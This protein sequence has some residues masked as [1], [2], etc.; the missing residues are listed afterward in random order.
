MTCAEA[1]ALEASILE[2][3]N[4][5]EQELDDAGAELIDDPAHKQL[6]Q[7]RINALQ[8]ELAALGVR[9]QGARDQIAAQCPDDL[10]SIS[11]TFD[12]HSEN[13]NADT[14]LHVFVKNRSNTSSTPERQRDFFSNLAA[15]QRHAELGT[16]DKNPYLGFGESLGQGMSFDAGS[17]HTFDIPLRA[18]PIPMQEIVLPVVNVHILPNGND[19]WMFSYTVTFVFNDGRSF[20]ATS[21]TDGVTGII[22]DQ[23]QNNRNHSG[24]CI[25]NPFVPPPVPWK[26]QTDAV[27]TR[28]TLAFATHKGDG[29]NKNADTRLNIHIANRLG[30]TSAQDIAVSL[31]VLQGTEFEEDSLHT[32]DFSV[33]DLPL[34]GPPVPLRDIVLPVVYLDIAPTGNDR[35]AF[36]YQVTYFFSNGQRFSSRTN[37][38]VLDQHHH[39]HAGV[40]QGDPFPTVTP[41]PSARNDLTG[42]AIDHLDPPKRISLSYLQRRLDE[43]VNHRQGVGSQD[44]PI[45]RIRLHHSGVYGSTLPESSYDLQSITAD[46]PPPGTVTAPSFKERVTW[47]S[48]P[49]SIG[50]LDD[51]YFINLNTKAIA[52]TIDLLHLGDPAPLTVFIDFDV[53]SG[54]DTGGGNAMNFHEFNIRFQF[55][56]AFNGAHQRVDVL[57]WMDQV[58]DLDQLDKFVNVKVVTPHTTDPGGI[59]QRK[60]RAQIFETLRKP[61]PFDGT[62]M[63]DRINAVVNSWLLGETLDGPNGCTVQDVG[64]DGDE[65]VISYTGPRQ[66]FAPAQPAD[67]PPAGFSPGRLANIDHIVVLTMENRSFDHLLGYLSLPPAKGGMGRTDVDGLQGDEANVAN[68]VVCPS[69]PLPPGD[70]IFPPDPPHGYEPVAKAINGG[71]MDGFAQSYADAHGQAVAPRIMGYHTAANV[72]VYDLLARDFAVGHRWFASHPGPTFCNR[73]YELTGRLNID[74]DSFWEYDNSS[75]PRPV[76][77]PTILDALTNQG[78]SWKY[79]EQHYCF[80]RL[81]EHH[82]F[83]ETNIVAFDDPVLGFVNLARVGALPSVSFI[84]PHYIE[85]PP[86]GSCDGPPADINEGQRLVHRVVE[87]IVTSPQWNRTL[88]LITYDEHGGFYDH[89]PPPA[90]TKVSPESLGTFGVRVPTFVVSPWVQGGSVFG[91]DGLEFD[92]TSIPKTIARRFLHEHPPYLSARYA[93]ANDLS[94]VVGDAPRPGPF[95]PFI[96]YNLDYVTSKLRLEVQGS[97]PSPGAILQQ[98][99]PKPMTGQQFSLED[100]GGGLF[101][102]R[103]HTGGLYLTADQNLDVRQDVKHR[104][105][106]NPDPQRWRFASSAITMLDAN[107][108]TISNAAFPG[109]VLQPAGNSNTPGIPV[110]LGDPIGVGFHNRNKW[111]ATSPLLPGGWSGFPT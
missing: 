3:I 53:G 74:P 82:T 47:E 23:N 45:R 73:F 24:I 37:G 110:V 66:T 56:L 7:Q 41:P 87:A 109:K 17:S 97:S 101:Y 5:T 36:D 59:V 107:K 26:P 49:T 4:G 106:A 96:P 92:H 32:V 58:H 55:T 70:T 60:A 39:K 57:R 81:F 48:S 95:L 11:I 33:D 68:G 15:W 79:F 42:P 51:L 111:A 71:K 63:R 103:T 90:A 104:T 100:A 91:H 27:L 34:A 108:F 18:T 19:R 78:V 9:L 89:I 30:P 50:R 52:V 98:G 28:V 38:V 85:L 65:L 1:R 35:W 8:D 77:T 86:D 31:D 44:P 83:D 14:V 72:P 88:L 6:W 21:D 43:F 64:F 67:W 16:A 40:Y 105:G 75:P 93:A 80:L 12:T 54:H 20:S 102:I 10:Q 76:F 99:E 69:F 46:P 2:S 29:S 84:D 61:D 13:K 22:L 94:S 25:E 62:T